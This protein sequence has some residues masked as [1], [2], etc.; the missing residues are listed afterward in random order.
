[1]KNLRLVLPDVDDAGSLSTWGFHALDEEYWF[2]FLSI[3]KHPSNQT[4][5]NPPD[6]QEAE[7][8]EARYDPPPP[9]VKILLHNRQTRRQVQD[10]PL[11]KCQEIT[12]RQEGRNIFAGRT[13]PTS[14]V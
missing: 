8:Y 4:P 9:L 12:G 13:P 14:P 10:L 2:L 11:L 6:G 7:G 3:R 1:M 5:D